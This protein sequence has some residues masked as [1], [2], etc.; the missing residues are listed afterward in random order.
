MS[1]LAKATLTVILPTASVDPWLDDA[2]E[3]V[4]A[5]LHN[6]DQLVVTHDGVDPDWSRQWAHDP[7]VV[8]LHS[9]TRRGVARSL[10]AA[11]NATEST[12]VARM[13]ADDVSLPG[14]LK[15]QSDY[16]LANPDVVVVS[17]QA[18]RI[19]HRGNYL[20]R[21]R[22]PAGERIRHELLRENVVV[23]P[24]VMFRRDAYLESGGYDVD[25]AM[26]EDYHLWLK[27]ALLGEVTIL[28]EDLLLYRI[29]VNQATKRVK[30]TGP[31]LRAIVAAQK[32]L[33]AAL[34]LPPIAAARHR[35]RWTAIQYLMA[36]RVVALRL[37]DRLLARGHRSR[38]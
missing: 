36:S 24:A 25:L 14:R 12:F 33:A 23:H 32:N 6:S 3:S 22:L 10:D 31:H 20:G 2:V 1:S 7:R 30:Q 37:G 27:M 13:D 29:H 18:Q 11:I 17:G 34:H 8:I 5:Q 26:S 21:M 35:F 16:L 28:A 38:R 9:S 15:A 4:L 19:D